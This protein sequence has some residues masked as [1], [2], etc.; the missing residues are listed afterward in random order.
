MFQGA[1]GLTVQG[2]LLGAGEKERPVRLEGAPEQG[3][4]VAAQG[5]A[6]LVEFTEVE[7]NGAER[8]IEVAGARLSLTSCR[9]ARN[10]RALAADAKSRAE[11]ADVTFEENAIGLY[12]ANGSSLKSA[13]LHFI[14]H[15]RVGAVFVNSASG[16]LDDAVF[17]GN[18][19]GV[20]FERA[21]SVTLAKATFEKNETA[22]TVSQCGKGPV[23]SFGTFVDNRRGIIASN[24]SSPLVDACRFEKNDVAFS[25]EQFSN[26]LLRYCA[27]TENGEAVRFDKK[28]NGAL[29]ASR[30]EKNKVALFADFSSY[31]TI[32]GNLFSGNEWHV[33]LGVQ[34][35]M[36]FERRRGSGDLTRKGAKE[37]EEDKPASAAPPPPLR[38][39]VSEVTDGVF[40]VAGNAWDAPTEEEMR[41]PEANI[42]RFWDGSDQGPVTYRGF[43]DARYAV[44]VISYLPLASHDQVR[45][46]PDA[47]EPLSEKGQPIRPDTE[48][49]PIRGPTL[50]PGST[51]S[52]VSGPQEATVKPP[53]Q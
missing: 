7:I 29:E 34:Q 23:F 30:L 13:R 52:D 11:L 51:S 22:A 36:D 39:G 44:D 32:R 6:S 9:F 28:S 15:K 10:G 4:L 42:K 3:V 27:F 26:P 48:A 43:G 20:A 35:S 49:P 25:A 1:G 46:G 33:R 17:R 41:S 53:S 2:R 12:V 8:G 24:F 37:R 38:A 45:V 31:P 40:S 50:L 19:V 16:S 47:W 21:P 5:E 18:D 14:G